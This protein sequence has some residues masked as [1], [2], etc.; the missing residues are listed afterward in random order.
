MLI[1]S[2]KFVF[3]QCGNLITNPLPNSNS[4]LPPIVLNTNLYNV[5]VNFHFINKDD[6]T[7][8]YSA[9]ND[10]LPNDGFYGGNGFEFSNMLVKALNQNL[11]QNAVQNLNPSAPVI[12]IEHRFALAGVYFWNNTTEYL[13]DAWGRT[14][15]LTALHNKYS[16]NITQTINLYFVLSNDANP[17]TSVKGSA[18]LGGGHNMQTGWMRTYLEWRDKIH[19][20]ASWE[21]YQGIF[22]D[23]IN[24]EC[25]HCLNLGHTVV[26]GS[27]DD[28]CVDTPPSSNSPPNHCWC[29]V[30]CSNNL[31]D[32][33]CLENALSVCQIEKIRNHI[34]SNKYNMLTCYYGTSI[35]LNLCGFSTNNLYVARNISLNLGCTGNA[36]IN[37]YRRVVL[38]A[39]NVI[40]DK[41][42]E[43][44]LGSEFETIMMA[45]CE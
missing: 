34:L 11:D 26:V 37:N 24:H 14:G 32:Y 39:E 20:N 27:S 23:I 12:P 36:L 30:N 1:F 13:Y 6:G 3:G 44:A 43:V 19:G 45:S 9:T 33:N 15:E 31:M 2:T 5:R 35:N 38:N 4:L 7:G 17:N 40:I 25:G 18:Y 21:Y 41:D 42:F 29:D 28:G 16:K 22:L 10:P 8:N